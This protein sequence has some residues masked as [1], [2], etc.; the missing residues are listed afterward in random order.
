[1]VLCYAFSFRRKNKTGFIDGSCKR[2]NTYEV[3]G[4]QWDRVNDVVLGWILN[5]VS[6]KLFLGQFFSKRAKNVWEELKETYDKVDGSIMFG[7]YHKIHTL[8]QNG[9]FIIDYYHKLN[10]LWKQSNVMVELPKEVLPDVRS[11][12]TTTSSEESHKVASSSIAGSSQRNQPSPFVSN[13]PNRNN[14]QRS[15]HNFNIGSRPNNL[16]NNRQSGGSALH[17]WHY[18]LGHPTD[19]MLNVL[20]DNLGLEN[21]GQAIFCETCQRA[22]Q[23]RE[24]FPLNDHKSS[25]LGDL[26]HLDLWGPYKVTNSKGFSEM[27]AVLRNNTWKIVDLPKDRKAIGSKWIF[28]TKYKSS[29][30]ID[31]KYVLDLLSEHCMLACKPTKTPLMSKLIISNEATDNDP[32]LDNITDHHQLMGLVKTVYMKPHEGYFSLGNKVCGLKKSLYGLKQAPRQWNAKLISTSTENGFS[33]NKSDYSLY[34][35]YEKGVYLAWLVYVDDII[36]TGN[37]TFEIEKF[38][39]Y[40]KFK[41]MIKDLSKLKYFLGIEVID[42]SKVFQANPIHVNDASFTKN[43]RADVLHF[44]DPELETTLPKIKGFGPS[45]NN[46]Q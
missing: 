12:Y 46:I 39:V 29:D 8:K 15:N 45:N 10:D 24:H 3:L 25:K 38:K 32:I 31:R 11:A 33:Q 23:T 37:N 35:K 17:D 42:A 9:S 26:I 27:D 2:S 5:S 1:M 43:G 14:F 41:F 6:E 18:R 21:K 44:D 22:K 36:I 30:E 16:N 19:P 13:V 20:K 28:K 40:L 34:T 7:L 4:R